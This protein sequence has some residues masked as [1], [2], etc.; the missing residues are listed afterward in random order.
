MSFDQFRPESPAAADSRSPEGLSACAT[1]LLDQCGAMLALVPDGAYAATSEALGGGTIGKHVRHSL[2]HFAALLAVAHA[3]SPGPV[4][5]DRR[6]RDVPVEHDRAAARAEVARLGL[7]VSELEPG[8]A[9]RPVRVRVMLAGDGAEAE[10]GSTIGRELF[11]AVHHA[12]HH[13]AMIKAIAGEFGVTQPGEICTPPP[14]I[15][16][17]LNGC[18]T[19]CSSKSRVQR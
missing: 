6:A 1:A 16:I 7:L 12:I 19:T 9:D 8:V 10:L 14:T 2:D 17:V 11:F 3:G 13:H 18:P 15:W 5:Y 4:D